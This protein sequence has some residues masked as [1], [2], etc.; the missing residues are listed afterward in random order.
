VYSIQGGTSKRSDVFCL[1]DRERVLEDTEAAPILVH[2]AQAEGQHLTYE[3]ILRSILKHLCDSATSEFLF[4]LDF[5]EEKV[6]VGA[7][8]MKIATRI[9]Y[10]FSEP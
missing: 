10:S 5:F 6:T 2:V 9:A 7:H 4:V 3:V 8:A 1:S